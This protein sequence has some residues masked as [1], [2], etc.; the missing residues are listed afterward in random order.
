MFDSLITD[1]FAQYKSKPKKHFLILV[2]PKAGKSQSIRLLNTVALPLLSAANCSYDQIVLKGKNHAKN[3]VST[4]D[5]VGIDAIV[6][7]SGDGIPHEVFNGLYINT[8][9]KDPLNVPGTLLPGGSSNGLTQNC[10]ETSD[11]DLATIALIK[12]V[13]TKVDLCQIKT[14]NSEPL[15]SFLS[16]SFGLIADL[17]IGTENLR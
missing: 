10:F 12:N 13:P 9:R 6:C 8:T 7:V 5:L 3:L 1:K 15:I 2:N 14:L 11:M 4:M 16:T 17:D